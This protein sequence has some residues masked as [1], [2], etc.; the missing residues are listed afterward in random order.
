VRD[1]REW[2]LNSTKTLG[3]MAL[4]AHLARAD[5]TLEL[6]ELSS[7]AL[8]KQAQG[9]RCTYVEWVGAVGPGP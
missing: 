8:V 2:N 7:T 9:Q 1:A 5:G 4:P 6:V 3:L